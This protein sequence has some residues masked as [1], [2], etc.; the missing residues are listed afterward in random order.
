MEEV[1]K[2]GGGRGGAR[3]EGGLEEDGG[4]GSQCGGTGAG[5]W[6]RGQRDIGQRRQCGPDPLIRRPHVGA[7]MTFE[8]S[9][10]GAQG[11]FAAQSGPRRRP[12]P[13]AHGAQ[14]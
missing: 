7:P 3:G 11:G 10:A 13:W 5:V 9:T 12:P 8:T 6:V 2:E 14:W 4:G 1:Q